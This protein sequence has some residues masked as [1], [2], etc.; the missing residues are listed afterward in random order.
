MNRIIQLAFAVLSV[1]ALSAQASSCDPK[2]PP[3]LDPKIALYNES[4][5]AITAMDTA[6]KHTR[7]AA[8][9]ESKSDTL[10]KCESSYAALMVLDKYKEGEWRVSYKLIAEKVDRQYD[11]TQA[12]FIQS[13]CP[14]KLEL[15]RHL[16]NKGD[17]WAMYNLGA[18]YTKG[19]GVPQSDDV[20]LTWYIFAAEKG[21]LDAY[22]ALGKLYSDGIA[23]K[24]DYALALDW[25]T[26]AATAGDAGAQYTVAS[27]HRKGLGTERDA[28]KAVEWYKKAAEQKFEGA[29][30]KLEEMYKAGEAKRWN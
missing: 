19:S 9:A 7:D 11:E 10:R 14:Q 5:C 28:N 29:K 25:Y 12:R 22:L 17:A 21:N 3:K 24:P 27:M 23:F 16:A 30:A 1:V 15:Y 2:T 13:T 18:A 8:A 26:K 20:A 4:N 6:H